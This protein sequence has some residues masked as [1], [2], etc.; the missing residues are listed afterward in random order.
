[1]PIHHLHLADLLL[2]V[3]QHSQPQVSPKFLVFLCE[4]LPICGACTEKIWKT[5]LPN[6]L[7]H[8]SVT[9]PLHLYCMVCH[10]LFDHYANITELELLTLYQNLF[11]LNTAKNSTL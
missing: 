8:H 5:S 3:L 4:G 11:L 7:G 1:M 6:S 2:Q 10:F 9:M